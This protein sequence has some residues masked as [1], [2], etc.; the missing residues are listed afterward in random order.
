[1]ARIFYRSHENVRE[2]VIHDPEGQKWVAELTREQALDMA[3]KIITDERN[4]Q[5]DEIR[6]KPPE[7]QSPPGG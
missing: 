7:S 4:Q 1:M 2:L 6:Q 3:A 5:M